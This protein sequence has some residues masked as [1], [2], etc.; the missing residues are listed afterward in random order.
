MV[1]SVNINKQVVKNDSDKLLLISGPCLLENE[2]LVR[3][4][5]TNLLKYTKANN[6]N[7]VFKCSFDKAN[8]SSHETVRSKIS[9]DKSIEILRNLKKDL[10]ISITTDIHETNQIDTCLLYTSPSPRDR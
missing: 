7:F 4:V 3:K 6:F 5:A 10:N 1:K 8:R 9:I 2:N